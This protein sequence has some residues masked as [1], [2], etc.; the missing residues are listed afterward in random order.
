MRSPVVTVNGS[1][2]SASWAC[3]RPLR[4]AVQADHDVERALLRPGLHLVAERGFVREAEHVAR[5]ERA[6]DQADPVDARRAQE[7]LGLDPAR[8]REVAAD[9]GAG[10]PQRDALRPC[11]RAS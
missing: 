9:A 5:R 1:A 10:R 2:V 3:L 7:R 11:A 8:E 4:A 6:A